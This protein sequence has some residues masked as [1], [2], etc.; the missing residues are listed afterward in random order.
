VQDA[1]ARLLCE[2]GS[3]SLEACTTSPEAAPL[4]AIV[5]Q[6]PVQTVDS[7]V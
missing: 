1:A 6:N 3:F 4:A 5:E 7:N 2:H